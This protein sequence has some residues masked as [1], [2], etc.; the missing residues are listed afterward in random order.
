MWE[1]P[2]V[3]RPHRSPRHARRAP[4]R[5]M[6]APTSWRPPSTRSRRCRSPRS[7]RSASASSSPTPIRT[8]GPCGR[9]WS[10]SPPGCATAPRR[11]RASTPAHRRRHAGAARGPA[12]PRHSGQRVRRRPRARRALPRRHQYAPRARLRPA[13]RGGGLERHR[14]PRAAAPAGPRLS[15]PGAEGRRRRQ[16]RGRHSIGPRAGPDRH[17]YGLEPAAGPD[18]SRTASA[19]CRAA[20][21]RSRAP[22]PSARRPA[23]RGR[24]S[25][26]ATRRP[27]PTSPRFAARPSSSWPSATC[28]PTMRSS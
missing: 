7:R 26:S 23:M 10:R 4:I 12:L 25:R 18:G 24:R 6:C 15:S 11:R 9:S 20:S 19:A 28:S 21:S 16:R 27:R 2:P 1:G 8:A 5:P 14:D 3:A 17:L 13:L 22:E